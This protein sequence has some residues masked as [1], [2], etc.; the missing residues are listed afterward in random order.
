MSFN[1][2]IPIG[3]P[4]AS[5]LAGEIGGDL[6]VSMNASEMEATSYTGGTIKVQGKLKMDVKD[7][8][9]IG[10][11]IEADIVDI[12]AENLLVKSVQDTMKSASRGFSMSLDPTDL[13][14]GKVPELMDVV[15]GVYGEGGSGKAAITNNLGS[16][17]GKAATKVVVGDTLTMV[18]GLIANASRDE[19]GELTTKGEAQVKA[20]NLIVEKLHDYDE[21]VTLGLGI[22]PVSSTSKSAFG[23][24]V[25][26]KFQMKDQ[27][28][29]VH[30]ALVG[31]QVTVDG[32]I[33]GSTN[34]KSSFEPP[35]M[36]GTDIDLDVTFASFVGSQKAANPVETLAKSDVDPVIQ[37]LVLDAIKEAEDAAKPEGV[38]SGS[39][40]IELPNAKDIA[41]KIEEK[42]TKKFGEKVAKMVAAKIAAR[43]PFYATGTTNPVS[44]AISA[45][46]IAKDIYDIASAMQE[47]YDAVDEDAK[48]KALERSKHKAEEKKQERSKIGEGFKGAGGGQLDPDSDS[49][50]GDGGY[51]HLDYGSEEFKKSGFQEGD[52]I[53]LH[54][55]SQRIDG[56]T[57]KDPKSGQVIQ[58][59]NALHSGSQPHGPSYWKLFP[60]DKVVGRISERI[61]TVSKDGRW[62]RK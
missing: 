14:S 37:E 42:L 43:M 53:G 51:D 41:A 10:T 48:S 50:D 23:S 28:R 22:N 16:I 12:S 44:A 27:S 1:F 38:A 7:G 24:E 2:E 3:T 52:N 17:V 45:G 34:L 62:I 61:G 49:D 36:A 29:D 30:S 13:L 8:K 19:H 31:L 20:A 58:K 60:N 39:D 11:Q 4:G 54:R 6:S 21:G 25:R 26:T 57:F 47:G 35:K 40:A 18:G 32:Q 59:D 33:I 55:F 9:V 46:F 56:R 5:S 15:K